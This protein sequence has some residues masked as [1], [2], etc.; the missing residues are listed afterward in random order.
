VVNSAKR[1]AA[2]AHSVCRLARALE[3]GEDQ[4]FEFTVAIVPMV[5]VVVLIAFATVVR[6]S[7]MPAW[8]A[9]GDCA[10]MAVATVNPSIG[11]AQARQAAVQSLN[12][13]S[14]RALNAQITVSGDWTPGSTVTCSVA[15]DIDVTGMI[16]IGDFVGGRI[17]VLAQ[18]SLRVEP[19]KSRWQ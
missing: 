9:A 17:P 1:S 11:A 19:N 7:Q 15:Y 14:I 13:N 4:G 6:A 16:G 5:M 2:S 3:R 8:N 12:G 18:V 10:R